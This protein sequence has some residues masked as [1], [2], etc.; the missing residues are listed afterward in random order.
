MSLIAADYDAL[1]LK[2]R[3]FADRL[4]TTY[5]MQAY[6][7]PE[8][9]NPRWH[10]PLGQPGRDGHIAVVGNIYPTRARLLWQLH[11]AGIPLCLY[12]PGFSRWLDPGPLAA[13]HTGRF[14]AREDK[15]QVFRQ[16]RGVLNNL[17]PAEMDSVNCRLFEAAAS[18]GA[19]LCERRDV[20]AELFCDGEE[21]LT[22]DSFGELVEQ[23]T[24]L[25]EGPGETRRIGDAASVRALTEHTYQRRLRELL[26]RLR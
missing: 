1:F 11:D 9:C 18:G 20:L 14:V 12:G 7:L 6:Y 8:A 3:L 23:C 13:L 10:R 4:R 24:I 21:V 26:D 22:F 5:R 17:H 2:D 25:M 16:A 19:V 15:A